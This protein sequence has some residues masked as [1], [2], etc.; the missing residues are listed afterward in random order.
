MRPTRRAPYS[1][2]V[3]ITWLVVLARAVVEGRRAKRELEHA[4]MLKPIPLINKPLS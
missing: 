4:V 2:D 1:S 3:Q